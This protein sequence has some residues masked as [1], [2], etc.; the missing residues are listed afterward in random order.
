MDNYYQ[1]SLERFF[2]LLPR[3]ISGSIGPEENAELEQILESYPELRLQAEL[4]AGMWEQEKKVLPSIEV[5]EAFIRHLLKHRSEFLPEDD[6]EKINRAIESGT[7]DD[8]KHSG[9]MPKRKYVVFASLV[10]SFLVTALLFNYN[11]ETF[12]PGKSP[13]I[14][15]VFTKYGNKSKVSLPDGSSV[16]LNAGSRLEYDSNDFNKTLREVHLSGEAYFDIAH[17]PAKPFIV[18]SGNMRIK[19]LGTMFN[20]KAYPEEKHIETSLIKGSVEITIKDRPDDKYI[21]RPN[22]KLVISNNGITEMLNT[23]NT[24]HNSPSARES[25]DIVALK[26]V[27]YSSMEKLV[28]ETAWVQNKLV[29]R[30]E[31]FS[32]L[33]KRMERWYGIEIRFRNTGREELKFTGIFTTETIQQA[34]KAMQV[35]HSFNYVKEDNIIFID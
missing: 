20:V 33:A 4:F 11:R 2:S 29:F 5:G 27:D 22:E 32:D 21:L 28:L 13:H 10:M 19:V 8:G 15:S 16:W 7:K 9:N 1:S 3:Q 34:L 17:N 25:A 24:A 31:K 6:S 12:K 18:S 35:V 14:S 26:K 30:S 23:L